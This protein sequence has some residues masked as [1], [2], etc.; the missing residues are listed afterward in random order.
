MFKIILRFVFIFAVIMLFIAL[1]IDKAN[2]RTL[3]K[4]FN[5]VIDKF[6]YGA[7]PY[8]KDRISEEQIKIYPDKVVIQ[9]KDAK[10]ASFAD[11]HSEEPFFGKGSNAI[12]ITP[13]SAEDIQV[14]DII[15][16]RSTLTNEIIIHRVISI[17]NDEKGLY[18]TVKG[19]NNNEPD[20]EK[21]RFSRVRSVLVGV[22]Y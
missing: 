12:Q 18:Y 16:Y 5:D 8:P 15:S 11:T 6:V 13:V 22:I 4:P 7:K 3:E 1:A 2:N 20:P 21:V 14:G 10:Y 19:D 9:I 17:K